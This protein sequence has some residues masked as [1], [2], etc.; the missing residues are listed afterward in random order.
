MRIIPEMNLGSLRPLSNHL[1]RSIGRQLVLATLVFCLLFTLGSVA[2][3]TWSAWKTNLATMTSELNLIDQVFRRTLSKAVWEMDRESFQ[4][5][6]ESAAQV[7][8]VGR[9]TLT[10]LRAGRAAE[11]VKMDRGQ[12]SASRLTPALHRVLTVE[13]YPGATEIVGELHIEGDGMLLW[14]RLFK[15]LSQIVVT[16]VIQSLLLSG[17]IMYLFHRSV[18]IHVQHIAYHLNQ[19]IPTNLQRKLRL[20][21][22]I[23]RNDEL[24]LLESGVNSLQ[25][26]LATHLERQH[27]AEVA[28]AANRDQLVELIAE[29]TTELQVANAQLEELSRSDP[30]TQLANRR[31]FDELKGIEFSR[32]FRHNQYL[33]VLMCDVDFFKSYNDTYGHMMGDQCLQAIA[34]ILR[35]SFK[36]AGELSARIGGEEFVVLLPGS[37]LGRAHKAAQRLQ[38]KLFECGV[39]HTNS[40][41]SPYVTLSI[42]VAQFDTNTMSNFDQLLLNADQALYRAKNQGRNRV[43]D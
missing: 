14:R 6:L 27:S 26:K 1:P 33:S 10:I 34:E 13:P 36:R 40:S 29:R 20:S 3:R 2:F 41:V 7:A 28:L 32:A 22:P 39:P 30:L 16:Q 37:D 12:N 5:Q 23:S 17:L 21:R 35:S 9:V 18:T 24:S 38:K 11:V 4:T 8:P 31:H 43:C 42:G 19:L 25:D 15:E